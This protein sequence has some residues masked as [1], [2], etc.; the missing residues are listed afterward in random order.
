MTAPFDV[1][2]AASAGTAG[3]RGLVADLRAARAARIW[4]EIA[5]PT[6]AQHAAMRYGVD[7]EGVTVHDLGAAF[8]A[9]FHRLKRWC[10]EYC[11]EAFAVEPIR[12]TATRRGTGR[13]FCF[14]Y[15]EDAAALRL[16]CL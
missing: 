3:L 11:T 7:C 14:A 5:D 12:D 9:E 4:P 13:R 1:H 6:D 15:E 16:S 2:A 8:G 10:R